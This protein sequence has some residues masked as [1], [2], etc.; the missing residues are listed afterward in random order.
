METFD[1]DQFQTLANNIN[2]INENY[3]HDEN[4]QNQILNNMNKIYELSSQLM[5]LTNIIAILKYKKPK[6]KDE[7]I[8]IKNCKLKEKKLAEKEIVNSKLKNKNQTNE[9]IVHEQNSLDFNLMTEL[10]FTS[11]C[12]VCKA[13][14]N[15][16]H[17]FYDSLCPSCAELNYEKRTNNSWDFTGK[18]A[19]VTGCRIKIGYEIC[20]FLLRNGCFVIGT[21]RFPKDAFLRFSHEKDYSTFYNRLLIYPLDLRDL[22]SIN[23]FINY[24]VSRGRNIDILINNAA[25]TL[26][27]NIKF[28]EHLLDTEKKPLNEFEDQSI[29]KV[30]RLGYNDQEKNPSLSLVPKS[31]SSNLSLSVIQSQIPLLED[32]FQPKLENFPQNVIDKDKQQVD[33]TRKSSWTLQIDEIDIL[34]FAE[35][36]I[37]NTWAPFLLVSKLKPLM[38]NSEK[39]PKFI[40]NVSSME[41]KFNRFK[42]SAHPHTNMSKAALNMMTRTCGSYYTNFNIYM[43]SVDTGWVSEMNSS[44]LYS[45]KRTV[46][47]DEI[48]GAMRVLDPIIQGYRDGILLHSIFLKDYKPSKW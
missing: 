15:K 8:L 13:P 31:A 48:D 6:A 26:R 14:F 46:P 42:S 41:G 4:L 47:L 34:E 22:R 1:F 12:Y 39:V 30:L 37:I 45:K 7:A 19:V 29:H 32:D 38:V 5:K 24:L 2:L 21:T 18:I 3:H 44:Q 28:Y 16:Y 25:Q 10:S 40:V 9:E 23:S 36:Q 43:T 35:T 17:F 20:L 33:L 27:R 11:Y